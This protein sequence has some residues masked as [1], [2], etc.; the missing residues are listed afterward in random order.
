MSFIKIYKNNIFQS[1]KKLDEKKIN[2]IVLLLKKLRK[3]KGRLLLLVLVVALGTPH[4]QLM[5]LE[6]YAI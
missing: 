3:N 4:M 5:I 1:L 6:N 2:Q